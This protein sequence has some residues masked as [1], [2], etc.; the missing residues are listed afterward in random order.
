MWAQ[1]KKNMRKSWSNPL[2]RRPDDDLW[3]LVQDS[4]DAMAEKKRSVK[5]S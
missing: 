5:T 4:R 2:A 3:K 1:V